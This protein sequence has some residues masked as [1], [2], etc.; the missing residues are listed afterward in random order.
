M[1][2][3]LVS[4]I[5]P[6]YNVQKYINRCLDS[7]ANQTYDNLEILLVD[8]GSTDNSGNICDEY[9]AKDSRIRCFHKTN[10]G[11]GSARNMAIDLYSGEYL[12]FVDSD[13]YLENDF[14]EIMF[15]RMIKD[16]LDI[17]SCNYMR[18]TEDSKQISVFDN[19]YDDFI[20]SGAEAVKKMWYHEVI[21]LAPWGKIYKSEIWGK[22]HFLEYM[23]DED[24]ATMHLIYLRANRFGYMN[25]P[26]VNYTIRSNSA[27][28]VFVEKKLEI[29]DIAESVVN[30]CANERI[31]LLPAAVA[32]AVSTYFHILMKLPSTG[33]KYTQVTQ[34][35]SIFIKR[36]R[37]AVFC[38][39]R[40]SIK[41]K[42]AILL[43]SLNLSLA[44]FV[45]TRIKR[46]N[47]L[48]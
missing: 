14:V 4:I 7:L 25:R 47:V 24:Y 22:T 29:L 35:C 21:N 32:K 9:A 10:G 44:R 19:K 13:D 6:V 3:P 48:S 39:R 36:H 1:N 20:T 43:F 30:Y 2:K 16:Q 23:Y 15:D 8:D 38:D 27:V 37:F 34:R 17:I 5:V 28:R 41:I 18:V 46:R 40:A 45:Y 26:L 31:Y 33:G 11:Q 12:M 42:I